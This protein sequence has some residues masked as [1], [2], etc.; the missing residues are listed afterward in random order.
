MGHGAAHAHASA[1][2]TP[3]APPPPQF[4]AGGAP[5]PG[6]A[7]LQ[8]PQPPKPVKPI[9]DDLEPIGQI[10]PYQTPPIIPPWKLPPAPEVM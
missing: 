2:S 5:P 10:D 6:A 7:P 3:T 9:K 1:P 8:R 4:V